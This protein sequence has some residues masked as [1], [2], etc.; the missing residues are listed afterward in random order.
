MY[1]IP[2]F[3]RGF[4]MIRKEILYSLFSEKSIEKYLSDT[5]DSTAKSSFFRLYKNTTRHF[6]EETGMLVVATDENDILLEFCSPKQGILFEKSTYV[7]SSSQM[8]NHNYYEIIS[9]VSGEVEVQ[10][11]NNIKKYTTGD[12]CILN[13]NIYH[14]EKYSKNSCAIYFFISQEFF[15]KF[16][17]YNYDFHLNKELKDLFKSFNDV[18]NKE[19]Q[20]CKYYWE[21][22]FI[23]SDYLNQVF[24]YLPL[25][26]FEIIEHILGYRIILFGL[27]KRYLYFLTNPTHFIYSFNEVITPL[28]QN[29]AH[30][31]KIYIESRRRRIPR[32][33]LEQDLHYNADYLNRTFRNHYGFTIGE[34][35]RQICMTEAGSLLLRTNNSVSLIA[36]Q[37]GYL[38]RTQFYRLFNEHYNM[39]PHQY[40]NAFKANTKK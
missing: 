12:T 13:T 27:L 39:T 35:Q 20:T 14:C 29:V 21:F 16:I 33:E 6:D 19:K 38:N 34:Y 10:V 18:I 26:K 22:R 31:V 24:H 7:E 5:P 37:L 32:K 17:S 23:R 11:E 2:T 30:E 28:S 25:F 8:H 36:E 1:Q 9:V 40:R 15:Q 3:I 4:T